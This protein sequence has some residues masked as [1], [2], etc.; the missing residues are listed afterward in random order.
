MEVGGWEL[1]AWSPRPRLCLAWPPHLTSAHQRQEAHCQADPSSETSDTCRSR[2]TRG[3]Y[4]RHSWFGRP[5]V[6][7]ATS[8]LTPTPRFSVEMK[9]VGLEGSD[10]LSIL[11]GCPGLPGAP[12]PK[13]E[14]GIGG[15]KAGGG[16]ALRP[17][18]ASVPPSP[19]QSSPLPPPAWPLPCPGSRPGVH[20]PVPH[21]GPWTCKELLTRGH[22]PSSWHTIYLPDCR[23]LCV[24]LQGA[25]QYHA[26]H[27]SS[28]NGCYLQGPHTGCA[29]GISWK[30][31][32]GYNYS[33]KVRR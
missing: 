3:P 19:G 22:F 10:K 25:W 1:A 20:P 4:G 26:Y 9:L 8:A 12:G 14:A 31:W 29:N 21:Q 7:P 32:G 15:L 33:C 24:P 30:S 11:R 28:L 6:G 27:S 13:G 2:G 17:S 5:I 16:G 23:P 18:R